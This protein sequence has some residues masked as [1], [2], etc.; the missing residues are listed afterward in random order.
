MCNLKLSGLHTLTLY[1][2]FTELKNEVESEI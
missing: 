1:S 2:L